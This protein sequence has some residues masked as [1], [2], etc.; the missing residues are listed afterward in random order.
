MRPERSSASNWS[1]N[2]ETGRRGACL[3]VCFSNISFSNISVGLNARSILDW[4][5]AG[6]AAGLAVEEAVPAEPRA[7]EAVA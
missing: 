6:F 2:L 4:V 1:K 5:V 7:F 3:H